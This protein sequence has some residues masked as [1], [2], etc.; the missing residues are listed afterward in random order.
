ALTVI[1][2][3]GGSLLSSYITKEAQSRFDAAGGQLEDLKVNLFT[4]SIT[5]QN[6]ESIDE[7]ESN[8]GVAT[9]AEV[10]RIVLKNISIYQLVAHNA[11]SIGD[12]LITEGNV[13]INRAILPEDSA[14]STEEEEIRRLNIERIKFSNLKVSIV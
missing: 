5:I 8:S 11:I 9:T 2:F 14:A 1:L 13:A 12:V 10:E 4:Q 7:G 6:I 3:V